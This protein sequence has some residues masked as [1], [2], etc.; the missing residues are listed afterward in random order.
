MAN[1]FASPS[2][3]LPS[4]GTSFATSESKA[5]V[6]YSP[7]GMGGIAKSMSPF[8]KHFLILVEETIFLEYLKGFIFNNR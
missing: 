3:S 6:P 7:S 8:F 4:V 5:L 2:I 1:G